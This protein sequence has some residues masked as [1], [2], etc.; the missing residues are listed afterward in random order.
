MRNS[1]VLGVAHEGPNGSA[2][3][4]VISSMKLG[5]WLMFLIATVAG[6]AEETTLDA[7]RRIDA[8]LVRGYESVAARAALPPLPEAADDATFLRRACIDL[9]GRLPHP[10]EV[11][12]Y[13]AAQ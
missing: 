6:R 10:E 3:C 4:C 8:A 12:A 1:G 7:A 2:R 13:L 11:Q 9:A 5:F